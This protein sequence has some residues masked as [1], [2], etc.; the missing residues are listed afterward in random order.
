[1]RCR[2]Y[3]RAIESFEEALDWNPRSIAAQLGLAWAYL[4][5]NELDKAAVYAR[6]VLEEYPEASNTHRARAHHFLGAAQAGK[7]ERAAALENF[8]LAMQL[9]SSKVEAY[10][11]RAMLYY[12]SGQFNEAIADLN[13]F[14]QAQPRARGVY[15]VRS[16]VYRAQRNFDRAIADADE[17]LRLG[18]PD[19]LAYL[20][21]ST[22]H[23]GKGNAATALCDVE[24]A[25]RLEPQNGYALMARGRIREWQKHYSAA[26]ADYEA[27]LARGG[28]VRSAANLN[29]LAWFLATCA[30]ETLRDGARAIALAQEACQLSS[31][32]YPPY[33]DTLAAAYAENGR[34]EE[35][36]AFQQ[37][38][39]EEAEANSPSDSKSLPGYRTRLRH[40]LAKRRPLAE[41]AEEIQ[42]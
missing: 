13:V 1:M 20:E 37:R 27:A 14:L 40:Y 26:G 11:A 28:E 18:P 2:E 32:K 4:E 10:Y 15:R 41:T 36:V 22:A 3:D 6:S 8:A 9:D 25:V 19:A 24:E 39:T 7:N 30:D 21:R 42:F 23:L 16:M 5:K 29:T 38:A 34:F 17:M 12:R 35:A 33:L 31:W